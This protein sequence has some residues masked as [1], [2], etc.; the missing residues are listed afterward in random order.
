MAIDPKLITHDEFLNIQK[1][2]N[3]I[4]YLFANKFE[5]QTLVYLLDKIPIKYIV[6]TQKLSNVFLEKY[7]YNRLTDDDFDDQLSVE[8]VI[9]Y[10]K[11]T[12]LVK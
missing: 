5:E 7:I 11:K 1:Q 2:I 3:I 12:F 9:N 10:Q 6:M 8:D 4:E